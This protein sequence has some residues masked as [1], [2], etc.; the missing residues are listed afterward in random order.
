MRFLYDTAVFV[1]ARG[2]EHGNR[3][4]CRELVGRAQQGTL[5]GE[6]SV[7]LVQEYAHILRRRGLAA[8]A[9]RDQARDVAATCRVHDFTVDDLQLALNLVGTHPNLSVRDGAHAATALRRGIPIIVSPDRG[10][11]GIAGLERLDPEDAVARL[12]GPS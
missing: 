7:E 11:D 2:A 5:V 9:V 4:S 1:Y 6:A 10:F 8:S 12:A 3:E